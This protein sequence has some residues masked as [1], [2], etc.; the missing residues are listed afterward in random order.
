MTKHPDIRDNLFSLN[1]MAEEFAL[2]TICINYCKYYFYIGNG[3]KKISKIEDVNKLRKKG[4]F[5]C[6]IKTKIR[7]FKVLNIV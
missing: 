6:K 1:V 7:Y 5:V 2:Q 4:N 3:I